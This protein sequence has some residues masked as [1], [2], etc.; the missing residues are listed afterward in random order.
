M[1]GLAGVARVDGSALP[2]HA[3]SLLDRMADAVAHRG[4]DDREIL[5]DGPVG[6]A[7]VRLSLV[8]PAHGG[9]PLTSPDGSVVLIANGEIYN[10]HELAAELPA[11]TRFRTRSDCEVL[12]HLYQ[13]DGL[14]FL[15]RVRG[16]YAI[17][18]WDRARHR[19]VV[20]RDRF[21]VKP[22]FLH[23]DAERVVFGS[24]M[25]ALFEDPRCPRRV[26]WAG[27]LADQMV[28][29]APAFSEAPINTWFEGIE[30]VPAGT[31]V[32][33][34]LRTGA[35]GGRRYWEFPRFADG[36]DIGESELV[37]AYRDAFVSAVTDCGMADVEIGLFLSG[38]IDSAAVAA[39]AREKPR[40]F[41]VLHGS[42]L[43]NGD[44]E[45][46]HRL[47]AS[48]G[49]VNHQLLVDAED[50]PS[51]AEWRQ[52]VWLLESPLCGPEVYY[53]YELYRYVGRYA[54]E[55]KAML[56]GGGSDEF[57]GGYSVQSAGG[58]DWTDLLHNL[59]RMRQRQLRY[60]RPLL[61]EWWEQSELP[62]L[63]DAVLGEPPGGLELSP[64]EAMF[65]WKYR[66]VQQYNCWHEDRTAAGNGIE[67]RVPFL[68][69]RLVEIVASIP[70]A[71]HHR[72]IWDK[73]I[74]RRAMEGLLPAEV[75]HRPKVPFF[76]G[77]G[78]RHTY[79]TFAR[80]VAQNDWALLE[81]AT[82]GPQA[83]EFIDIDAVRATVSSLVHQPDRG[84]VEFLLRVLNLGLL[85]Q[86]VT[87]PPTRHV[88]AVKAP[89][90]ESVTIRDWDADAPAI[91][92]QVL[93]PR[94]I[95]LDLTPTVAENVL[96][97][98]AADDPSTWYVAV[99]GSIE[100]VIDSDEQ[101]EW[102]GLLSAMDGQKTLRSL[103]AEVG[104]DLDT[105]LNPLTEAGDLG[106]VLLAVAE[107]AEPVS[108]GP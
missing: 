55:I 69:H 10:H 105:V 101:P 8:D 54:P 83:R 71:L 6:L 14:R 27:S 44:A 7:F 75:I 53:K 41:T 81:E 89:V 74:L 59:R 30:L 98:R 36:G 57:N 100:Y 17:V 90:R 19:L 33:I 21:G 85:E 80:M 103:L 43:A 25:K 29:G 52:L 18:L 15:D 73:Q 24:E 60:G 32:T 91:R 37:G 61:G 31:I 58:G 88:A 106:L 93:R 84:H 35:R 95:E 64:L 49:L 47:A 78:V 72:L 22:L 66:D 20:A 67:A 5:R 65:R 96:L 76:Y 94:P 86:L 92:D 38:G 87:E 39:L 50:V 63:R 26:D 45:H 9:Q 4:P 28:S 11:G 102:L 62:L 12:L 16:M 104:C 1:C 51:V 82:A 40:T 97:L 79:R 107:P 99:D 13:R 68:D 48:L 46:A 42:T 23:Q 34:D 3:D 56:L 77:D 108:V 70:P 2:E